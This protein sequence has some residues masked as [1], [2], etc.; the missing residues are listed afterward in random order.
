MPDI[1]KLIIA[2]LILAAGL[3]NNASADS[4]LYRCV[5]DGKRLLL[6]TN[7]DFWAGGLFEE[8]QNLGNL[9]A[10]N[11]P[12]R[13][14]EPRPLELSVVMSENVWPRELAEVRWERDALSIPVDIVDKIQLHSTQSGLPYMLLTAVIAAES[15][16]NPDAVSHKGAIGLMQVMPATAKEYGVENSQAL[17]DVDEN[18]RVGTMHLNKLLLQ[19]DGNLELAL[20]AYNAGAG[21]VLRCGRCIPS[22][23]ETQNYVRKIM[24]NLN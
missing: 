2:S 19:F 11:I 12:N 6:T 18:L 1:P 15:A 24:S 23:P 5:I 16:F 17:F 8:C 4:V 20:A 3:I 13:P 21:A 7:P 22:Y 10:L 14:P 9:E